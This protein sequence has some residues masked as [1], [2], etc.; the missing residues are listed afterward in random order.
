MKDWLWMA[1]AA[2]VFALAAAGAMSLA[3]A[4]DVHLADL[5]VEV[6]DWYWAEPKP[7]ASVDGNSLII[8]ETWYPRGYGVHAETELRVMTPPG[9]THFVSYIGIDDEVAEDLPASVQFVIIGDGAVLFE[10]PVMTASDPPRRVVID[11]V[12][13]KELRLV[14]NDGGDSPNS[15]HADWANARFVTR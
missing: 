15:D 1:G 13:I 3:P 5:D 7:D 11:V 6:A 8:G 12:G 10:S 4:G 14:A 9:A 2:A